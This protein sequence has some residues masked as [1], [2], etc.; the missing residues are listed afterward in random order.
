MS[1]LRSLPGLAGTGHAA[2]SSTR[3]GIVHVAYGFHPTNIAPTIPQLSPPVSSRRGRLESNKEEEE[4]ET[5][6]GKCTLES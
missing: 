2:T 5:K 3:M 6:L 4:I 1:V